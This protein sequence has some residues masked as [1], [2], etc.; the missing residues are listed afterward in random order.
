MAFENVRMF[1]RRLRALMMLSTRSRDAIREVCLFLSAKE[2]IATDAYI[3]F[4][5][6]CGNQVGD[7]IFSSIDHMGLE[8][9]LVTLE[10]G[11]GVIRRRLGASEIIRLAS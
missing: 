7:I 6:G 1:T 10:I 2:R 4:F 5:T 3:E 11:L 9:F 8:Q